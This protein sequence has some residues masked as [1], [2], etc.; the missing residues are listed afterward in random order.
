MYQRNSFYV[1]VP[2]FLGDQCETCAAGFYGDATQGNNDDCKECACPGGR[3]AKNQ[4]S[5]RCLL[6]NDNKPTCIECAKG[7]SGRQCEY[8]SDGYYGN[9]LVKREFVTFLRA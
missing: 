1:V 4:F 2:F 7:Y 3:G 9:P 6:D 8:C 5:N